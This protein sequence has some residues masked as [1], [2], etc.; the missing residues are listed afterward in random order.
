MVVEWGKT[1]RRMLGDVRERCQNAG[2]EP[3]GMIFNKVDI[4]TSRYGAYYRN[5]ANYYSSEGT[6]KGKGT[7]KVT[8][9]SGGTR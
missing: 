5:Y 7:R 2:V 6:G 9:K 8:K 3:V 1:N 4:R